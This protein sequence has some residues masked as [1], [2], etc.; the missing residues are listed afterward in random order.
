[1]NFAETMKALETAGTEQNRKIY[2][3]HGVKEPQFGVSFAELKNLQKKI[4]VDHE[5]ARELWQSGNHDARVLAS[6]ILN[7]Q[8]LEPKLIDH[9]ADSLDQHTLTAVLA[10]V[11]A[12]SPLAKEYVSKWISSKSE[13]LSQAGWNILGQLALSDKSLPESYFKP[14]LEQIQKQIKQA[15]NRTRYAMNGALIA[16]GVRSPA[17]ESLA[18]KI[19]AAIGKVEVA[20]GDTDCKTP[21]ASSYI[22][23]TLDKKGHVIKS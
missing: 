2:S 22:R 15:P 20:H 12:K 3:K 14:F 4:K 21:D 18:L 9:W 17:L 11:V 1:M 16:M 13:Y 19:A 23:K 8:K 7:P 5:L 6:M 10:S